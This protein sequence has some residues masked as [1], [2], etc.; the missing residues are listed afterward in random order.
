MA[1]EYDLS[2]LQKLI[3]AAKQAICKTLDKE[4]LLDFFQSCS[5]AGHLQSCLPRRC[6]I[7]FYTLTT[8]FSKFRR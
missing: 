6:M 5:A 8:W 4:F 7:S 3:A 2:R 1:F